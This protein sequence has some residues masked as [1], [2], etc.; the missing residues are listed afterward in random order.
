MKY[1]YLFYLVPAFATFFG[2]FFYRRAELDK[3]SVDKVV[4][5][6][7]VKESKRISA[8]IEHRHKEV[9][10]MSFVPVLNIV[11]AILS[12]LYVIRE[13][14]DGVSDLIESGF[15]LWEKIREKFAKKG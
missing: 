10:I 1:V 2:S 6:L 4:G 13:L 15:R 9:Y 12:I 11:T 7:T 5:R 8:N 3:I 14:L